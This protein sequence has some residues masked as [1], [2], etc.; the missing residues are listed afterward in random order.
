MLIKTT[1]SWWA[2]TTH[3]RP[4]EVWQPHSNH[5]TDNKRYELTASSGSSL[6]FSSAASGLT[7]LQLLISLPSPLQASYRSLDCLVECRHIL[8]S[9]TRHHLYCPSVPSSADASNSLLPN[10]LQYHLS[11]PRI[12][13]LYCSGCCKATYIPIQA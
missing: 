8:A 3:L 11:C 5:W 1:I 12:S 7:L 9:S 10:P 13:G 4:T 6:L 2:R